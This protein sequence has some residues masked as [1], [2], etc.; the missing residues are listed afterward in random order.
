[1]TLNLVKMAVG[2]SDLEHL[3]AVQAARLAESVRRGEGPRL[4]HYTRNAP[5]RAAELLDG[6]S[7]YW[8][9][10]GRIRARQRVIGLES[11]TDDEGRR[12]CMLMLDPA[13]V[14]T[15]PRPHRAIQGWRYLDG[16]DAPP[17]IASTAEDAALPASLAAE[18][19]DM[20]LL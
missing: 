5:R 17:D 16:A 13:L 15:E 18:L 6:G 10:K 8:I 7:L 4:W 20:G 14:P 9:V 19:R 11:D 12:Y 3:A 1:M 2:I